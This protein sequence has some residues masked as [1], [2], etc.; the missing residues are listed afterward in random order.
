MAYI[1]YKDMSIEQK[2]QAHRWA[3]KFGT[4]VE[5]CPMNPVIGII[6][7]REDVPHISDIDYEILT[8][9]DVESVYDITD[10][11]REAW[12]KAIKRDKIDPDTM[13]GVKATFTATRG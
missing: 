3:A 2:K 13:N 11:M 4:N 1:A 9:G 8:K 12:V 10:A 7:N 6:T 5:N